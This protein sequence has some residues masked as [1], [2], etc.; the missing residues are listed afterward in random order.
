M[1]ECVA[2]IA[3]HPPE[4]AQAWAVLA[5]GCPGDGK[6]IRI[7]SRCVTANARLTGPGDFIRLMAPGVTLSPPGMDWHDVRAPSP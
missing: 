1:H 3:R 4:F 2:A 7:D 6:S 5:N